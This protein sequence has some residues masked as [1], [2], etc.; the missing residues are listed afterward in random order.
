M[1]GVDLLSLA[2]RAHSR[3]LDPERLRARVLSAGHSKG[4]AAKLVLIVRV[5]DT[6]LVKPEDVTSVST[7][8]EL[9]KSV[10][11]VC[12]REDKPLTRALARAGLESGTGAG[13]GLHS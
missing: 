8:Y 11:Q 12:D 2:L 5:L 1:S 3:K 10:K 7:G 13:T 9:C 6:G 4:T